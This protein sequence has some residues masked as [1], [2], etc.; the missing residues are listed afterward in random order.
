MLSGLNFSV[1]YLDD[2][3]INSKSAFDHKDHVHKVFAKTQDYGFKIKETKYD[4]FMEKIKYPGH[5]IDKDGK[6]PDP[7]QADAIK[8]IPAPDN[9]ASLKSFLGVQ[10]ITR[11]SYKTC[12]ICMLPK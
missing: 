11:H 10:I 6:R 9:I 7:E 4:F 1:S 3:L 12:M 8:D 5:I 2:F